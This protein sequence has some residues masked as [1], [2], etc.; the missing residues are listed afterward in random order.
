VGGWSTS[1]ARTFEVTGLVDARV[2]DVLRDLI[3]N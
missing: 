2:I 3:A 1:A